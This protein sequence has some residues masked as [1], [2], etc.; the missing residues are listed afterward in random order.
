MMR[1]IIFFSLLFLGSI[2]AH[3]QEYY[4]WANGEKHS[5][6]LYSDKQ[7]ILM[8]GQNKIAIAQE[9]EVSEQSISELKPIIISSTINTDR[10]SKS[11]ESDQYWAFVNSSIDKAK[12]PS[13]D[14]I[15]VAPLF[16]VNGKE[17]GL[18][19]YFYVKLKQE[20]DIEVLKLL[21]KENMV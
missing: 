16:L 6:E 7:Y 13:S 9:L 1:S 2:I 11:L 8:Q 14:I 3:V 17:I 19:H 21:A 5:L 20:K 4:Y 12:V 10:A 15:Y 18:S